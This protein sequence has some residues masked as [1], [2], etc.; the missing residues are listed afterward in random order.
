MSDSVPILECVF[1]RLAGAV[2]AGLHRRKW[3][4]EGRCDLVIGQTVHFLEND[5]DASIFVE[6]L[7]EFPKR[8][9]VS[10]V[11][12]RAT[13]LWPTRAFGQRGRS[14]EVFAAGT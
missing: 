5:K 3:K 10:S 14:V 8:V 1:Q 11:F 7:H 2:Q 13:G 6:M 9:E 12:D 4:V